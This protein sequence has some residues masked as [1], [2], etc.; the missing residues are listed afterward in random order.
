MELKRPVGTSTRR[1]RCSKFAAG[2]IAAEYHLRNG[3]QMAEPQRRI[4][5][6]RTL[7]AVALL[8]IGAAS[9][10]AHAD[11]YRWCAEYGGGR[12]GST[13]CYFVTLQQCEASVSG[14]GGFCRPNGFYTGERSRTGSTDGQG[15]RHSSR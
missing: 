2:T 6:R 10:P 11:P 12:G 8:A 1:E 3:V 15:R 4:A 5:M 9:Q 14:N 13:N 7:L